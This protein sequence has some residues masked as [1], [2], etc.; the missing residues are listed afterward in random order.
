MPDD[1]VDYINKSV[2]PSLRRVDAL[3]ALRDDAFQEMREEAMRRT[4]VNHGQDFPDYSN[5]TMLSSVMKT[6]FPFWTYEAHR[7]AF[8]LPREALRH[9]GTFATWG[10]YMDNSDQGYTHIPGTS[11][12]LNPLRGTI[13]MGGL[14]RL[15]VRD[16]P[17]FY[18]RF[19]G[20]SSLLDTVGR[21]GFYPGAA[22]GIPLSIFGA[23]SGMWQ[24]GEVMPTWQKTVLSSLA[25]VLPNSEAVKVL[26]DI[27]FSDRFRDFTIANAVSVEA[28]QNEREGREG[29]NGV[30]LLE[31]K[32]RGE[33]FTEEEEVAWD[34]GRRSIGFLSIMA[35]QTSIMRIKPEEKS[36][37][38]KAA[39]T[40]L[41]ELTDVPEYM[42]EDMRRAGVRFE[43]IFGALPPDVHQQL[44]ALEGWD[45]FA[46][47]SIT[48]Q[49]SE[50]G[51]KMAIGR[52]FWKAIE[53]KKTSIKERMAVAEIQLQRGFIN[54]KTWL[55]KYREANKELVKYMDELRGTEE[56]PTEYTDVPIT[57]S[58]RVEWSKKYNLP[59]PIFH[60]AEELRNLYFEKELDEV[61]NFDTGL[62][63]PDWDSFFAYRDVLE[64][65]AASGLFNELQALNNRDDT[66]LMH[67]YKEASR[68]YFRA[69]NG[70]FDIVLEGY[71]KDEQRKIRQFKSTDEPSVRDAMRLELTSHPDEKGQLL[72]ASFTRRLR[73][74]HEN[75]RELNPELD[76][77]LLFFGKVQTPKTP[78]ALRHFNQL[79]RDHDLPV[80]SDTT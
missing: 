23:K 14:R 40:A 13:A 19:E 52:K 29:V 12:D 7:W 67:S 56:N 47:A 38:Q 73:L 25:V 17:E 11:I 59:E 72:I 78:E 71:D 58:E 69:Y 79:R 44:S 42:I 61:Y 45:Y 57:L 26:Q 76:A 51:V 32:L 2:V 70:L 31:K 22:V 50:L 16:Y 9:P 24:L 49:P 46:G 37:V 1:A 27:V 15:F 60:A 65:S 53:H 35:E 30:Y 54:M 33:S 28:I 62:I 48:L 80:S 36:K 3:Q 10:K 55:F 8:Y 5:E 63:E 21:F 74:A 64:Q 43:D 41:S 75:L 4:V 34:S 68:G 18:D 39:R 77:W 66:N 20:L 6:I